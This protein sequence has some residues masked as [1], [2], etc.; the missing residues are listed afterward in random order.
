MMKKQIKINFSDFYNGFDKENNDFIKILCEKYE[1]ILSDDP[2]Y[3]FYSSFGR[4][5]LKY[6]CIRIYYTGECI[7]PDFNLCDYAMAFE[8]IHYGDRYMRVPIYELFQYRKYYQ[9]LLENSVPKC[10]KTAFCSFVVSNDQG[11]KERF[12]MMELLNEYK[13]VDSG[14]R[15]MNNIGGPVK[16]KFTF[17]QSHKFSICFENCSHPGYTTEKI[18]E[19]FAADTIPVY[20]GDSEIGKH[21]NT[22]AFINVADYPSLE[23]AVKRIIEIDKNTEL[24]QKIKA[25]PILLKD[26]R[27]YD[28]LKTFLFHIIEQPLAEARRRPY[29]TRVVEKEDEQRIY[30]L[31][32]KYVGKNIKRAKSLIRRY[33]NKAL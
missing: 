6:D 1:V 20:F 4:D 33:K 5:Y 19:A 17:D 23:D 9:V 24:Y 10:K 3:L 7:V 2:D 22:H 29:N 31:Y 12:Q 16:D 8:Y 32:M 14:G 13:K 25:E 30:M 11:M 26:D 18:V 27:L 28:D 15:Y 21:F